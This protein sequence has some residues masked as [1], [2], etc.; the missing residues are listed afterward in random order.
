MVK[1]HPSA[2]KQQAAARRA[3]LAKRAAEQ[4]AAVREGFAVMAERMV[5][6]A[7]RMGLI[8]ENPTCPVIGEEMRLAIDGLQEA[9][10]DRHQWQDKGTKVIVKRAFKKALRSPDART[11]VVIASI[12]TAVAVAF[13]Y[14]MGYIA[15]MPRIR[16]ATREI[17]RAFASDFSK[18][19]G[20]ERKVV[21]AFLRSRK[22][23][24]ISMEPKPVGTD[25][26]RYLGLGRI[27]LKTAKIRDG[28]YLKERPER[29]TRRKRKRKE[30]PAESAGS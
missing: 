10:K 30:A 24:I 25:R 13:G 15:S 9:R 27:R 23:L 20:D 16:R 28:S 18:M 1:G 26:E 11:G 7:E 21:E 4:T 19:V 17:G 6:T 12:Y 2:R 29:G 3:A 22:Y 14:S 5:A 8:Y